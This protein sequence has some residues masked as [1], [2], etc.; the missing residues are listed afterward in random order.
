MGRF[1]STV[2]I[3]GSADKVKDQLCEVMKKRGFVSCQEDEASLSYLLAFGEGW[4]T[5]ASEK[6]RNDPKQADED[7]RQLAEGMN[8]RCFS[9]EIV[10]SDFAILKLFGGGHSD[11]VIVGDGSG[12]GIE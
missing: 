12:Y 2:Q 5:L 10:D 1:S 4:A 3:K 6:Y 8:T 11:E 9:V 7:A